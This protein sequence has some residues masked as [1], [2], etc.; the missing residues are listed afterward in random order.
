MRSAMYLA[1][2][3]LLVGLVSADGEKSSS[4]TLFDKIFQ[5]FHDD[6][7]EAMVIGLKEHKQD[8]MKEVAQKPLRSTVSA[9]AMYKCHNGYRD[10]GGR[11]REYISTEDSST[12]AHFRSS[13]PDLNEACYKVEW[14]TSNATNNYGNCVEITTDKW[15]RYITS[16]SVP[17]FYMNPYCPIGVGFGYCTQ[18][19]IDH[20]QC[21]FPNLTCGKD[22]G[23]GTTPYGD[24]WTPLKATF[25][26]PLWGDPTRP[27][28]PFDMYDANPVGGKKSI[29]PASGVAIN[30]IS[31]QGPN[32]AGAISIDECGFQLACGGHVTPPLG[33]YSKDG[34][35]APGPG[36]PPLY[37]FH[38]S[39]ECLLP[40]RNA[41]IEVHHGG[42]PYGH[43]KLFGWAMDG[44]GIY[45]YQDVGGAAPVVDECG[46]HFGPIDSS[47]KVEYH[48]HSR[49]TAPYHLACQGPSLGKCAETQSGDTNFCHPGCGADVCIQPGTDQAQLKKYLSHQG[50]DQNWLSKHTTNSVLTYANIYPTS[51]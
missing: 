35:A 2:L 26:I 48:Y 45:T 7:D 20:K 21:L 10:G 46:G 23:P 19:E 15:Y 17:D 28:R 27:D 32:D 8:V 16:N 47:G 9:D 43:G 25:R 13:Y 49:T 6:Y 41:S 33:S 34:V 18:Y 31:I 37:H 4:K 51:G 50:W 14:K 22:N 11:C 40:F 30:G 12:N 24:V 42:Q 29:G 38:K 5:N 44:F 3:C 36:G 1:A 39:P